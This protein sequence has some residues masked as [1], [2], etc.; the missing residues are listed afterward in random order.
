MKE[1][2]GNI[3][4]NLRQSETLLNDNLDTSNTFEVK[5]IR[6]FHVNWLSVNELKNYTFQVHNP[7]QV[8][9]EIYCVSDKVYFVTNKTRLDV[10][11]DKLCT[12]FVSR[13]AKQ[14][15]T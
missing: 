15:K 11:H 10:Y 3:P 2:I 6:Q 9:H 1:V 4:V 8:I 13:I 7:G 5:F 12:R 14:I